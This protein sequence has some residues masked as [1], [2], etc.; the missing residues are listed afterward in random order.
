MLMQDMDTALKTLFQLKDTG[1]R[2]AIDDFGTG[3]SSLAYLKRFPLDTLKI[4]RS[5]IK[6]LPREAGRRHRQG[7]HRHGAQPQAGR[8]SGGRG[9][10]GA[11]RLPAA[12]WL[13]LRAG[14]PV[15]PRGAGC[16]DPGF[17]DQRGSRAVSGG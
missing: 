4:D 16:G 1:V 3:H 17:A 9:D 2:L 5:F 15:Q 11:A 8:G 7:H 6:D 14:L 13:R 10:L 12:A